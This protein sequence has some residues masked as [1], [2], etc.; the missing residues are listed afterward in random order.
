MSRGSTVDI[1][2]EAWAIVDGK[3]YL[4]FNKVIQ[5]TWGQNHKVYIKKA[6]RNWQK[7]LGK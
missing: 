3:L 4:N 2:P 5:K 1:D 7:F 6:D